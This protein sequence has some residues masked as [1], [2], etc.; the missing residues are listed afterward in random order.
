[1]PWTSTARSSG[2]GAAAQELAGLRGRLH[3]GLALSLEVMWDLVWR[4]SRG[5]LPCL[6]AHRRPLRPVRAG[7]E[8]SNR[9]PSGSR[10]HSSSP[11]PA[12]RR[13]RAELLSAVDAWRRERMVPSKTIAGAGVGVHR[14]ARSAD[15][16]NR[17]ADAA[18]EL[19]AGA[20]V[21]HPVPAIRRLFSGLDESYLGPRPQ[22][23]RLAG[24]RGNLRDQ[25]LVATSACRVQ[26]LVSHE[27]VPGHVTNS[28]LI[29][30]CSCAARWASKAR[31]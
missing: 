21:Q 25:R 7:P 4:S 3:A 24:V 13:R 16:A 11:R 6:R 17:R 1:M 19:R 10:C 14:R 31:C 5:D 28:A 20:A 26:Q 22:A 23:R 27:V 15:A 30:N 8:P 9:P 12:T 18:A 2:S 29:Q